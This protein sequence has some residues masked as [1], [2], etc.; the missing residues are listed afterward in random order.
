MNGVKSVVLQ[1]VDP[2]DWKNHL[3]GLSPKRWGRLS[4]RSY[5]ITGAGTGYGRALAVGLA[6]TG[7]EV[8]L[9]GRRLEKLKDSLDEMRS[10]GIEVKRCHILPFDLTNLDEM[11]RARNYVESRGRFLY[12]LI[13]NAAIPQRGASRWP[14]QEGS[15]ELW[16]EIFDVNV[17]APWELSKLVLPHM[18]K[19][20]EV[21]L[22]FM[23]SA[24]AWGYAPG[25]GPYNVTKA[26]LNS[27]GASMAAEC[28]TCYPKL[29][30]QINIVDPGEAR[31]EMNQG[32]HTSP[33]TIVSMVLILLS[34]PRGGPNG[35]FFHSD[36]RHLE[37]GYSCPYDRPL[38]VLE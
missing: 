27:L 16:N 9:S 37:F 38:I 26:A 13:N 28:V 6:S 34:H 23:T 3:Y 17:R 2:R 33:Y 29:D 8:F 4:E 5:W 35:K 18:M 12:G 36:G 15:R 24:A 1:H 14:L 31:T 11:L 30:V 21:K 22:V 25:F 19:S 32:S 10:F 20:G 7:A